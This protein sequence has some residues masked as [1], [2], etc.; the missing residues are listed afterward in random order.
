MSLRPI[1]AFIDLIEQNV[2]PNMIIA[3]VGIYSGDTS[4][5][6]LPIL[7]NINAKSIL[8][9]WFLG[10]E[11]VVGPHSQGIHTHNELLNIVKNRIQQIGCE[12]IVTIYDCNSLEAARRIDDG[13]IDI[14]FI[15]ADH[16]Y[17]HIKKDIVAYLPKVKEGGLL[18]GHDCE[19]F[20]FV[21]TFTPEELNTDYC[22]RGNCHA[23]VVQAVYESFGNDVSLMG[24]PY[25]Q[26]VP[27]WIHKKKH[28][29]E[30]A[31]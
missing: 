31:L 22:H 24:D 16:R 21:N 18:C 2:R 7:K 5:H 9:D 29:S 11:G 10:S 1:R 3:E 15:D 6:Y 28:I 8:I 25:G 13:S 23:G 26:G 14:C 30:C 20:R 12:D 19:G 27:I 4:V 17:E